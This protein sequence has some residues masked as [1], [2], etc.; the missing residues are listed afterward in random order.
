MK[1]RGKLFK[2]VSIA[3]SAVCLLPLVSACGE[4]EELHEHVYSE[5][6]SY[7]DTYH[8]QEPLCGDTD[9]PRGKSVHNYVKGVCSLCGYDPNPKTPDAPATPSNPSEPTP[10]QPDKNPGEE[11]QDPGGYDPGEIE[12]NVDPVEPEPDVVPDTMELG[13]TER[14]ADGFDYTELFDGSGIL[15]GYAISAGDNLSA[16]SIQ[17]PAKYKDLPVLRISRRGF[18]GCAMSSISLPDS[19]DWMGELAFDSCKNLTSFTMPDS[20][21]TMMDM[22]FYGCEAL[23]SIKLSNSLTGIYYKTFCNCTS[24]ERIDL[25]DSVKEIEGMSFQSCSSL[26]VITFGKGL[27]EVGLQVFKDC[28][29]LSTL[30]VAS[31]ES[32]LNISFDYSKD[33]MPTY[34]IRH[35]IDMSRTDGAVD[36]KNYLT[37]LSVSNANLSAKVFGGILDLKTVKLGE[38][39]R[40]VGSECFSGCTSLESVTLD[41][42]IE[43]IEGLAFDGCIKLKDV[44]LP[45]SLKDLNFRLF[46]NCSSLTSVAIGKNLQSIG[47]E[48]F[49]N[50]KALSIIRYEGSSADWESIVKDYDWDHMMPY[51]R[52][53]YNS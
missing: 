11:Q 52:I 3:V 17:I 33:S 23:K 43:T 31:I 16:D 51:A 12:P 30:R 53:Q 27:E 9:E 24:L 8:W 1:N 14:G 50:C 15:A 34:Y 35:I 13:K 28:K 25:P 40:S 6:W 29:R 21:E 44:M 32:Y 49:L 38:G 4:P 46:S 42:G 20:V 45:A 37:D 48:V 18:G 7:D 26:S 2:I 41:D 10:S 39:V 22:C 5:K 47:R 36:P 19:I